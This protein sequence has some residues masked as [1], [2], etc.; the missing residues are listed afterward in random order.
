LLVE[1]T[2]TNASHAEHYTWG[3]VCDGWYL[4]KGADLSVIEERVPPGASEIRHHHSRARQFFY[5]LSGT[6]TLEFDG[7]ADTLGKGDGM[8]VSQSVVHRLVNNSLEDVLFLVISAP[9]TSGDRTNV[10]N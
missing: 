1:H 10:P 6:A 4:L 2:P 5:V 3:G 8:H 9:S 7:F